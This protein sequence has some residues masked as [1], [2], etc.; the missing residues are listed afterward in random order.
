M[1]TSAAKTVE[2]V[3]ATGVL[4]VGDT[5]VVALDDSREL[6]LPLDLIPWLAW[7]RD[8]TPAQRENWTLE[9]RGFA[10]YWPDLDDG[11][12]VAHLLS[13]GRLT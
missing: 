8:A 12:E 10:I 5:L 13:L 1:F 7:L 4:F 2:E 9:P 11:L 6:R 3:A